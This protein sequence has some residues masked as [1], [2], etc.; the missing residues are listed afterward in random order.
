MEYGVGT[1]FV[2]QLCHLGN[3]HDGTDLVVDH[4]NGD[5]DGIFP[6]CGFQCVE[7]NATVTVGLEVGDLKALG[8]QFFGAV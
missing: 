3:G 1:D 2:G 4:H 7:G 6:Q 5:Q 8:F